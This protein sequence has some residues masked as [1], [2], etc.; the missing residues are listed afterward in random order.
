[1]EDQKRYVATVTFYVY[2]ETPQKA[3]FEADLINLSI[4]NQNDNN[5]KIEK[6]HLQRFGT[7]TSTEIDIN[8]LKSFKQVKEPEDLPF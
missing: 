5:S 7:L 1:M 3:F 2:G 8:E 6:F 4:K